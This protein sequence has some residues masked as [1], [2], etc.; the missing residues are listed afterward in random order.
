MAETQFDVIVIG[1]GP[2]GYVAAIRAS[3]LGLKTAI[4]ERD[5]LGG[6]CLNWGCIPTKALLKNAEYMHFLNHA[7][8]F[9]F[10]FDNL[11]VD[12][13]RVIQRS[14]EVADANSNGVSFLMKK[15][16]ITVISGWG[17]VKAQGQVEVRDTDGNPTQQLSCRAII[18]A[19]GAR[20]RVFPGIEVD[21][22]RVITSTE[23]MIQEKLP[24]SMV[25]MGAGAIGVEFAYFYNAFGTKVTIVE[26]QPNIMPIEDEDASKEVARA[27][28]KRK[29][30]LLTEHRVISA[31]TV[32]D[33]VEVVVEDKNGKQKTLNAD[34]AL[35][36]VG[37]TGNIEGIGLEG[38]GIAVERGHIKVDKFMQTNVPGVYAIGDVVGAPWLAHVA[39]AEGVVAAEH[40]AGHH[41]PGMDYSN[42]PGCTYCQP[43]VASVGMTE[44]AARA[45]GYEL[46]IGKFPFKAS[47]KARAIG[48]TDGFV[49]LVIDAKYGEILGAHIVG[50]EATEMIAELGLARSLEA[51]GESVFRTIHAHPTLSEA[52]MEAAAD[53]YGEALNM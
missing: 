2:G 6:I 16:N 8:D 1:S 26:M 43:Q 38:L 52:V 13:Q 46:K 36:A 23:A 10:S 47:G 31:K 25:I 32:G 19:T 33:G 27:F 11:S 21:F 53:A 30:E 29:V 37:V 12:F 42:I 22:K 51:T 17:V 49:K 3:Q 9:G 5:R 20:P 40:I 35:N 14:R 44:K 48:E 45:A 41:T 50:S 15:N 24:A 7:S 18:L 28:K 39:S 34:L 4:V